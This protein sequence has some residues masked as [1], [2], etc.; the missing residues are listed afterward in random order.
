MEA[1][2]GADLEKEKRKTTAEMVAGSR[3]TAHRRRKEE[4]KRTDDLP[5]HGMKLYII[6]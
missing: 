6:I 5:K 3:P 2:E 1:V 4:D